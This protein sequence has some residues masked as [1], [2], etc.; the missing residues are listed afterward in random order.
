MPDNA[1]TVDEQ[2]AKVREE[3]AA[4]EAAN[5][6][7]KKAPPAGDKGKADGE[8][9]PVENAPAGD[10]APVSAGENSP[11]DNAEKA[12]EAEEPVDLSWLP[13]ESVRQELAK[14]KLP[15]A[16]ADKLKS[17]WIGHAETTR[18]F[19][20]IAGIK[21][22]A[23]NWKA[24]TSDP[25]RARKIVA[26]LTD[27]PVEPS[28]TDVVDADPPVDFDPLD[29]KS[30]ARYTATVAA[31]AAEVAA[32]KATE[33]FWQ[34]RVEGPLAKK[35]A[36]NGAISQ[37]AEQHNVPKDVMLSA[38][39][40]LK[41]SW[42]SAGVPLSPE[43]VPALLAPHVEAAKLRALSAPKPPAS[44]G[45]NGAN[46]QGGLS[47]V[48]SPSG[49]AGTAAGS[50]IPIPEFIRQNRLPQTDA[51]I[52]EGIRYAAAKRY[53]PDAVQGMTARR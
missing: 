15:K 8:A 30:V 33:S 41:E 16:V 50:T 17:G 48:A 29:P 35:E 52:D 38:V 6:P 20:E 32:R 26:I 12:P 53:G 51:E 19:Q 11:P 22:D 13:D 31:K 21:R 40:S 34:E 45:N 9:P 24:A 18:R 49:R 14:A 23:E 36:V 3:L 2:I 7:A 27:A 4:Y 37:Y 44:K 28:A 1:P 25:E 5:A 10:A 43:L 39:A 42:A 46:G 47:E